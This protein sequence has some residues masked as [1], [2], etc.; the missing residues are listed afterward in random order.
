MSVTFT[1]RDSSSNCDKMNDLTDLLFPRRS[2]YRCFSHI[3]K[4]HFTT[5]SDKCFWIDNV[6]AALRVTI[7]NK[8]KF[9]FPNGLVNYNENINVSKIVTIM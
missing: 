5:L 4:H 9:F 3:R 1:G 6:A 8:L 2:D 7:L